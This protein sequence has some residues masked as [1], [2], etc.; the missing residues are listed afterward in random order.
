MKSGHITS[1]MRCF[2]KANT[3]DPTL[4]VPEGGL[5]MRKIRGDKE[6][7]EDE[8]RTMRPLPGPDK[9]YIPDPSE[10]DGDAIDGDVIEADSTV[11]EEERMEQENNIRAYRESLKRHSH[12]DRFRRRVGG[13]A[14]DSAADEAPAP[15]TPFF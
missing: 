15:D 6:F 14:T 11:S 5:V 2:E 8:L 3:L 12:S 1:A 13:G 10:Q 9:L 7:T 4:R